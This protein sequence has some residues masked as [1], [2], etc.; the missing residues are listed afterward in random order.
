M[1]QEKVKVW[2]PIG[3]YETDSARVE[4]FLV[5][6]VQVAIFHPKEEENNDNKRIA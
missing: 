5:N 6:G 1:K 3:E 4:N 2:T